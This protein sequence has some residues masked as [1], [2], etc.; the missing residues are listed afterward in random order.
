[1]REIKFRA[2]HKATDEWWYGDTARKHEIGLPGM[3]FTMRLSEFWAYV[4]AD[5]LD[6]ETVGQYTGLKDKN[7]VEIYEGDIVRELC[8]YWAGKE[9][10]Y[11]TGEVKYVLNPL[12]FIY[13]WTTRWGVSSRRL[14]LQYTENLE[15][16]GNIYENKELLKCQPES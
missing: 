13:E 8:T 14:E 9:N 3:Q 5:V 12:G 16:I 6:P 1:M 11:W 7:G 10:F 2:R 15:V 4:Y